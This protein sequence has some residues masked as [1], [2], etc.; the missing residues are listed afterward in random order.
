MRSS[1]P[2]LRA[3]PAGCP[4]AGSGPPGGCPLGSGSMPNEAVRPRLLGPPDALEGAGLLLRSCWRSAARA[5]SRRRP[6]P[7]FV[8]FLQALALLSPQPKRDHNTHGAHT[9]FCPVLLCV[10]AHMTSWK[11]LLLTHIYKRTLC[12]ARLLLGSQQQTCGSQGGC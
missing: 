12:C 9:A 7:V 11:A 4:S 6:C 10:L 5:L 3:L 8:Q 2:A 1:V